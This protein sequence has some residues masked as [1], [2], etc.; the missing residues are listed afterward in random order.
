MQ[1]TLPTSLT[2]GGREIP[3]RTDYRAALD[4]ITALASPEW[5]PAQKAEILLTILYTKPIKRQNQE[6]AIK[7]AYWY[8][9]G[10]NEPKKASKRP[11]LI[12]W[13]KDFSIIAPPVNRVLGYDIRSTQSLHWWTF[14]SAYMEIGGDC[15]LAQVVNIRDKQSRG[16]KLEDYERKWA[17]RNADL[18]SLPQR[19]TKEE[20]EFLRKFGIKTRKEN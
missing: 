6:E 11:T 7:Q 19:R 8:L 15:L 18:I 3:I 14:L 17:R 20:E 12:D 5:T 10:G 1:Y 9:D 16:E 2:V 4:I 13:E